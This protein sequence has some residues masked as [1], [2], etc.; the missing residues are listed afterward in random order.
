MSSVPSPEI[1]PAKRNRLGSWRFAAITLLVVGGIGVFSGLY[2]YSNDQFT[3]KPFSNIATE[4]TVIVEC[5][6][7][8][9]VGGPGVQEGTF[10]EICRQGL[11][12]REANQPGYMVGGLAAAAAGIALFAYGRRNLDPAPTP[13]APGVDMKGPPAPPT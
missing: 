12:N 3:E 8:D 2:D 7:A 11:A 5:H 4:E 13:G 9:Q 6:G 1:Q 10:N